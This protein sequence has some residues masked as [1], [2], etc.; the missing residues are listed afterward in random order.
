MVE[1]LEAIFPG[2]RDTVF[3]VTS[4]A[5]GD[6]NCIA[7]AVGETTRWWWP[8][9]DT[10]ND[11]L[12][13]P[14]GVELET[15]LAAFATAFSGRGYSSGTSEAFEPGVEKIALFAK[16]G[17]PT[18]AARQ[19]PNGRWTSKLGRAEDV[20]HDLHALSGELYGT[21]AMVLKRA[22]PG[23]STETG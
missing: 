23:N 17:I 4:P 9:A 15:T 6:Y 5:T 7:W 8:D 10:D 1:G 2:L 14:A 13:W 16:D 11:A 21:V 19:L 3:H 20:E 18:H 12:Y 22:A